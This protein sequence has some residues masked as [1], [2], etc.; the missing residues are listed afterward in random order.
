M[1]LETC[2][3]KTS[4]Q[5]GQTAVLQDLEVFKVQASMHRISKTRALRAIW[6]LWTSFLALKPHPL[7]RFGS[8]SFLCVSRKWTL[9]TPHTNRPRGSQHGDLKNLEMIRFAEATPG[10]SMS[11]QQVFGG[12]VDF[13]PPGFT[14]LWGEGGVCWAQGNK[15]SLLNPP[16]QA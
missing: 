3:F 8:L 14:I 1:P 15:E 5:T 2:K 9:K 11:Q 12:C 7:D 16:C 6:D 13:A 4:Q 10:M